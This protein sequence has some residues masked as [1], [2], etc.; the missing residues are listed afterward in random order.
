M[1]HTFFTILYRDKKTR[2]RTGVMRTAHG[3][4][5]TPAFIPVAT[6]ATIKGLTI[7]QVKAIGNDAVLA[8]TYHLY[9]RPGDDVVRR[10]GGLHSFMGWQGPIVTDSGGFQVF[11][12]GA[13]LVDGSSKIAKKTSVVSTGLEKSKV[14]ISEEGVEFRSHIDGSR[15]MLTPEKSIRIQR[16]LG[17]DIIFTF[18]ECT[19]PSHSYRYITTSMDRTHRWAARSLREFKR[20]CRRGVEKQ[21]LFGIIQGG[22]Y[23]DLR[24]KSARIINAMDFDGIGIGGSFGDSKVKMYHMLS[25]A[26]ALCDES[27]PRHLLGIGKVHDIFEAVAVGIDSFDCVIPTRYGRNGSA[28][29][30]RGIVHLDNAIFK[31]SKDP[32]EDGCDCYA[33][34]TTTRGY[35]SHLFRAHEMLGPIL[36]TIH[37]LSF[38][39]R[40]M[41]EIRRAIPDGRFGTVRRKYR[42]MM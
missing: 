24:E 13:G 14:K 12:L 21:Y 39:E 19:S 9:L 7:D 5:H 11:S 38:M 26:L 3:N 4:I 10:F 18:D 30:R 1:S 33:C 31:N 42:G 40:L 32:L 37:N 20:A 6:Q 34:M 2:A 23:R 27:K 35:I 36:L 16:N 22:D 17:A 8:N 25:W 15:H 28:L 29:T 41:R